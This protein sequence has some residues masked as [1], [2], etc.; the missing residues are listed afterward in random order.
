[1]DQYFIVTYS[2]KIFSCCLTMHDSLFQLQFKE[3]EILSKYDEEIHGA[4][5]KSF[6]LG[7]LEMVMEIWSDLFTDLKHN[8]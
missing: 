8:K 1:M 2:T 7:K 4:R 3:K 6:Q 5:Q